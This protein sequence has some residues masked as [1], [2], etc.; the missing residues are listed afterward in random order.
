MREG[1]EKVTEREGQGG[2]AKCNRSGVGSV[3]RT[4]EV[5][6]SREVERECGGVEK[7]KENK[8]E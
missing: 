5:D 3:N 1:S 7:E 6:R 4:E 2:E 8:E